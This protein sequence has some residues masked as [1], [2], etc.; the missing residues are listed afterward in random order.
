MESPS[1]KT[2]AELWEEAEDRGL[3]KAIEA[4]EALPVGDSPDKPVTE[5][6]EPP[7]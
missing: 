1:G 3:D 4:L 2:E 5:C 6:K 7:H